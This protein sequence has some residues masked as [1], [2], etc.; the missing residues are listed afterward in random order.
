[1]RFVGD[2]D[3][4]APFGQFRVFAFALRQTEFFD[5]GENDFAA[6]GFQKFAQVVYR[7]RLL[8][9]SH[10]RTRGDKIVI[11][12]VVQIGAVNLNDE[13]RIV[14][15]AAQDADKE[16]HRKRFA[17]TLRVPNDA[18][19]SIAFGF[20]GAQRLFYR[21]IH[22]KVLMIFRALFRDDLVHFFKDDEMAN[23]GKQSLFGEQSLN[24]RFHAARRDC[25]H[26]APINRFP[27]G[28]P[29]H[30]CRKHSVQRLRA[31]GND[32]KRVGLE[33]F[34]NVHRVMLDLIVRALDGGRFIVGIF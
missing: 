16:N 26:F 24:E 12:L 9:V 15:A 4:V 27:R 18:D 7:F 23:V 10:K 8:H 2:D 3:D 21:E 33:R 11:E 1:M 28:E 19:A 22:A 25:F 13:R 14:Q 6:F 31:I 34:G 32:A 29:F 30:F 5:R 20:R 17:R